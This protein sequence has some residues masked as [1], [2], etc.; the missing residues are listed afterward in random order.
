MTCRPFFCSSNQ[1]DPDNS[2]LVAEDIELDPS[3]NPAR[4][5]LCLP[6]YGPPTKEV[7]HPWLR[8]YL[9]Q[10]KGF[11]LSTTLNG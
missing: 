11:V 2:N 3:N 1:S 5:E 7:A 10:P 4:E 9:L 8:A 6:I